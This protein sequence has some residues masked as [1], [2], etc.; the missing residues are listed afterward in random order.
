MTNRRKA[1]AHAGLVVTSDMMM[2]IAG[3]GLAFAATSFGIYMTIRGPAP[4][5]GKGH[6]FTVFAQLAPRERP[7]AS[8]PVAVQQ[9]APR[10]ARAAV[11]PSGDDLDT[12]PT[13]SIPAAAPKLVEAAAVLDA[14]E[15]ASA[16]GAIIDSASVEVATDKA[17]TILVAGRIRTVRV[18]D[19]VPGA[20]N[21][22]AITP[23]RH[24]SVKTTRGM[25]LSRD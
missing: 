4:D 16:N 5:F 8:E 21:V 24:P 3:C 14:P 1:T 23:G 2:G 17:A 13:A 20:G 12:T 9:D 19:S 25:I 18:G 7:D 10:L 6:D 11:P 22:V 15:D